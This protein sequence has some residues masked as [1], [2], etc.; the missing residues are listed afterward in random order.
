MVIVGSY[1]VER[2]LQKSINST[3]TRLSKKLC[4]A[5]TLSLR[6]VFCWNLNRGRGATYRDN[7][8][9]DQDSTGTN[10]AGSKQ[11]VIHETY[12]CRSN[13]KNVQN[14]VEVGNKGPAAIALSLADR[15]VVT[16][17]PGMPNDFVYHEHFLSS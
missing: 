3:I 8:Y 15:E 9:R 14:K 10:E 13:N 12:Y 7:N 16:V 1:C 2:N 5:S 6:N 4:K 11:S 17:V